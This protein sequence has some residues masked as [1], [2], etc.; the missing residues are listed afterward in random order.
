MVN[1]LKDTGSSF[2]QFTLM[3]SIYV[4][5]IAM[6]LYLIRLHTLHL[7]LSLPPVGVY[8]LEGGCGVQVGINVVLYFMFVSPGISPLQLE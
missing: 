5:I 3:V 1:R 4:I 2:A 6:I 8:L 7:T